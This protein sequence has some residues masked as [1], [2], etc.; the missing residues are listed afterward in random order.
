MNDSSLKFL[1]VGAGGERRRVAVR[2][3]AGAAPGL[4]WLGG[5]KSD[6]K[7]AKAEALAHWAEQAKRACI[8]FD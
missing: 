5:Y 6:M 4:F 2:E 7:G 8:R 3:Q 1:D